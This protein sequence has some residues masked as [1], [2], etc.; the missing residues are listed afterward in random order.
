MATITPRKNKEGKIISYQIEVYRGRDTEGRKLKPYSMNWKVPE[1]WRSSSVRKELEKV[2]GEF[3][4][5]CKMGNV[6]PEKKT[7]AEYSEY[8]MQIKER[9]NKHRTVLRYKQLLERI[10][11]EIGFLKLTSITGEHLNK[12]YMKLAEKGQNLKTGGYLSNKTILE[13]HRLIHCIFAQAVKE[14]LIRYN[15]AESATPPKQVKKE[16]EYFELEEIER[17]IEALSNEPLKYRAIIGLMI[18][19]GARRGE[20]AR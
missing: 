14:G 16:A 8:I 9:D 19:T 18:D 17:I 2:A 3:E 15:T 7:F 20:I 6:S 11:A 4:T 13:Y 10:N 1:G 12:F 5:N